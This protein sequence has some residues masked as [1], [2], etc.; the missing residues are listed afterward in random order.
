[1]EK[2]KK[3][4]YDELRGEREERELEER[5]RAA[6]VELGRVMEQTEGYLDKRYHGAFGVAILKRQKRS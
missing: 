3:S 1:M 4:R 6:K 2:G 5:A